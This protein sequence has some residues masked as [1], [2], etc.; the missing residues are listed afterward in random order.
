M[1][2]EPLKQKI[3]TFRTKKRL[4]YIFIFILFFVAQISTAQ[5][6]F[7]K[8][9]PYIKNFDN[10]NV[11][12]DLQNWMTVQTPNGFI[13][14]A[15]T[16]AL[17]E[18]DGVTWQSYYLPNRSALR[19]L[20]VD[21]TGRIFVGGT[22]EFGY[23]FP[24]EYGQLQ[25]YSLSSQLDTIDFETVWRVLK[26]TDGIYF[27]AG[28]RYLYKYDGNKIKLIATPPV[29]Q[30]YRAS[31]VDN[32]VY[33]YD[34]NA[35]FGFVEQDTLR[36]FK[37]SLI[38]EDFSVYFFMPHS[39][40]ELVVGVREHGLFLFYPDLD[41]LSWKES[42]NLKPGQ[43][44][45]AL[46][47]GDFLEGAVLHPIQSNF[48]QFVAGQGLYAGIKGVDK[49][50]FSTLRQGVVV[51]DRRFN[52][53]NHYG[54]KSGILSDAVYHVNIDN[55]GDFW[56][57]GEMGISYVRGN[58]PFRFFNELNGIEGSI[59]SVQESNEQLFIGT[60]KGLYILN[61]GFVDMENLH[62]ARLV[63]D[64]FLFVMN[65]TPLEDNPDVFLVATLR[66]VV[67]F[68]TKTLKARSIAKIYGTYDIKS[69]PFKKNQYVVGH[70]KGADVL[71]VEMQDNR[72]KR[73]ETS[74]LLPDFNENIRSLLFDDQQS[75]WAATAYN[76]V[77]K[78]EFDSKGIPKSVRN[79]GTRQGIS[80]VSGNWIY[81]IHDSL[82][83]TTSNGMLCY[84][85]PTDRFVPY[86]IS[87]NTSVL[88]T[89]SV[90]NI[91]V[92][93][94]KIWYSL[95]NGLVS[96]NIP[97]RR[98]E[99]K[100]YNRL[101][102]ISAEDI[103]VDSRGNVWI[104]AFKNLVAIDTSLV[105]LSKNKAQLFFRDV[106]I[107]NDSLVPIVKKTDSEN[108][109]ALP[110][111]PF[112]HNSL[113]LKI[114]CPAYNTI[115]NIQFSFEIAGLKEGRSRWTNAPYINFSYLPWGSF[116]LKV[117]ALDAD[118]KIVA[119]ASLHF[120]VDKPYYLTIWAFIVYAI[121]AAFIVF[122]A[123]MLNSR[124][125]KRV[126]DRLQS[127]IN[128]AISVVQQQKEEIE[129]QASVLAESNKELEKLSVVAEYTDN[130]VAIM[131]GKGNYQWINKGF[132]RM[133]GYRFGELIRDE[134]RSKIGRNSNL[135][136]NDLINIW[137]GNKQPIIY[138]AL[139]KCKGGGE[140]WV[141]TVLTPILDHKGNVSQLI[142][143]DTD[144]S[145]LKSAEHKIQDQRDEIEKQRDIA[146]TQRDEIMLQKQEINDSIYYTQRI[147]SALFPSKETLNSI[148]KEN[149]IFNRP[150]NIVSGDFFWTH[151]TDKYEL[152][153]VA[154]CTG[155]GVPGAFMSL[156]GL[157]FLNDIVTNIGIT[158]PDI[159]LNNLR[160]SIITALSQTDDVGENKD[161]MDIA[162]I[163]YDVQN[164][165]LHYAGA[166]NSAI[167]R[168][169]NQ[170]IELEPDKM[171]IS[172]Y[173]DIKAPFTL[174]TIEIKPNDILYMY[175]DG[176]IDQFGGKK[177]KKF[178]SNNFKELLLW[179]P[180][181]SMEAQ[182]RELSEVFDR[183]RGDLE[184]VDDVF[185][186][187]V[188][189]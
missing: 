118:K 20:E 121:L 40:Q 93:Q 22:R 158:R 187:G 70:V 185:V 99:T 50:Y 9:F 152:L 42:I 162:L 153:A 89:V 78:I 176:Y 16:T 52:V 2:S 90:K 43:N 170:L 97:T 142:A 111:I 109:Y 167:I 30:E 100:Y 106:A 148:F 164:R 45:A 56:L 138:E 86:K 59:L 13:Y 62:K 115:E 116:V 63:T 61:D 88:D 39:G 71:T 186:L 188:K 48:N 165:Q 145:K 26:T 184:Q 180:V 66:D 130:A 102:G 79:Y 154:D 82:F 117:Y 27:A 101:S 169:E 55:Y 35:G 33:F 14:A 128:E 139:N 4:R 10:L 108:S 168:R 1:L 67:L 124:R 127:R 17:L 31:V 120:V 146:L 160:E 189:L 44:R 140:I 105:S 136:I 25:Y 144:I 49:Y 32:T 80:D 6:I 156:I 11:P 34:M 36:L 112:T 72:L 183:W 85:K 54:K 15:N 122:I 29:L 37:N 151:R 95:E 123:V 103:D 155:H 12:V 132:T 91:L 107:G 76:G 114:A 125:L 104:S 81:T 182:G 28:R 53:I 113:K 98:I 134:E 24:N 74:I 163:A 58:T 172:I 119:A 173:R 68:D 94:N 174:Q 46:P 64:E 51:T 149:F 3:I 126:Q 92:S 57:S 77:F 7:E 69:I 8:G 157:N 166:N 178:K 161:G 75:L 83:V 147:Q 133:Y 135:R 84:H 47:I 19:S 181:D 175:S 96:Y 141:Q 179:L 18:F 171:P 21:S 177:G 143:I 150:R 87:H 73:T 110:A 137:Y 131:D 41:V 65:F 129:Q 23:F 38:P 159:V 60:T 5:T